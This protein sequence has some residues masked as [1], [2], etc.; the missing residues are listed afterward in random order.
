MDGIIV[1]GKNVTGNSQLWVLLLM[2][3]QR[4][5]KSHLILSSYYRSVTGQGPAQTLSN[6]DTGTSL[7]T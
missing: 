5:H 2:V 4:Q 1:N 6:L 3:L 7:G